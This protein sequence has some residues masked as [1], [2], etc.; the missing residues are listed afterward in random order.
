MSPAAPCAP[1]SHA[2][3]GSQTGLE[4]S[5]RRAE[6]E[7]VAGAGRPRGLG[8]GLGAAFSALVALAAVIAGQG[9]LAALALALAAAWAS[10]RGWRV[11]RPLRPRGAGSSSPARPSHRSPWPV[12]P[13]AR[14]GRPR[15]RTQGTAGLPSDPEDLERRADAVTAAIRAAQE[16]AGWDAHRADLEMRRAQALTVLMQ[17]LR[18]RGVETEGREA[19][20]AM[21][22]YE[23]ACRQRAEIARRTAGRAALEQALATRREAEAGATET[24]RSVASAERAL[25]AVAD[26]VG[27]DATGTPDQLAEALLEWRRVRGEEAERA[28]FA[29]REWHELTALLDGRPLE[30]LRADAEA[31]A[32]RAATLAETADPDELSGL[33]LRDDLGSLLDVEREELARAREVASAQRGALAEM[34]RDLPDVAEAEEALADAE[35][36]LSR[37]TDLQAV[38]AET[39]RLLRA[40]EERV[41]RDLAPI[42]A[43]AITRWLPRVSGGAYIDASVDPADLSVRVKEASSGRWRSALLLSEGTREQI[44]LLLRVAMAQQLATTGET[45]PLLLDEVTVQADAER[46]RQLLGVLHELST[47]RQIILFTHDDDVIDWAARTLAEPSDRLIELRLAPSRPPQAALGCTDAR[48]PA[49]NA[50]AGA[51]RGRPSR[52]HRVRGGR[53]GGSLGPGGSERPLPA[54]H[55]RRQGQRRCE[56]RSAA[57]GGAPRARAARRGCRDRGR[58]RRVPRRARRPGAADAPARERITRAIR[59]LRPEVVMTHDPTVLFVNNEW[60]N[61]PD[62][63]A[64]GQVAIDAVFPT[65]RDPLNFPEHLD[66]GLAPWKVAELF[67]WSTNEANQLV[68]IGETLDAKVAALSH[69]ESQFRSF[70]EIARWVRRR[71]EEL[72]ERAGYRAAEGFRRVT[73]AR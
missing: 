34:Q 9:L 25:R 67:L 57:A 46:K 36:E 28:D 12:T 10:A 27:L 38:L 45:A 32:T 70:D 71:S 54:R 21:A 47:E 51:R 40:A 35:A 48:R 65:A 44:Y 3:P 56:H 66:A 50:R 13:R 17:A 24:A 7:L 19:P 8:W 37:V 64:V 31:A 42:L 61:H 4:R 63:R 1:P 62:H 59:E 30:T 58:G 41:H 22:D 14:N 16:I 26:D 68:D 5:W 11:E 33:A 6:Q 15:P 60:V 23:A 69:H 2:R 55:A 49:A 43:A 72:G 53:H 73:L 39:T 20:D 52:R 29:R 18:A